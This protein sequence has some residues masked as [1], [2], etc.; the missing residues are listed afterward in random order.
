[1]CRVFTEDAT[2]RAGGGD[3]R[4]EC[5]AGGVSSLARERLREVVE[6]VGVG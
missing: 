1:M 5:A 4:D 3:G 2:L 6:V